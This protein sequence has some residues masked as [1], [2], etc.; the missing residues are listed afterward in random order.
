MRFVVD[1]PHGAALVGL[2]GMPSLR[3][4]QPFHRLTK[5]SFLVS[6]ASRTREVPTREESL[7]WRKIRGARLGVAFRRQVPLAGRHVVDFLAP[8]IKLLIELDGTYHERRALT[9][10]RRDAALQRL[11]Y[12][13]V[14]ISNQVVQ[15]EMRKALEGIRRVIDEG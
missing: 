4:R 1:G 13:I 15:S 2:R 11:G 8:S 7:L 10:A 9:D 5:P 12:R 3:R 6:A 14:R